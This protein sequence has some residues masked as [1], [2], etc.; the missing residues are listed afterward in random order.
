MHAD[1]ENYP[2]RTLYRVLTNY[3]KDSIVYVRAVCSYALASI[4]KACH[5]SLVASK[6]TRKPMEGEQLEKARARMAHARSMRKGCT[7]TCEKKRASDA[8]K[9][10]ALVEFARKYRLR[11]WN[12]G[13]YAVAAELGM[14]Y[15]ALRTRL[16]RA[17][18]IEPVEYLCL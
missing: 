15:G 13:V 9:R 12:E 14:T 11:V 2:S 4:G 10:Q 17:S 5:G 7:G 18:L 6:R 1:V 3:V 8:A 16:Y